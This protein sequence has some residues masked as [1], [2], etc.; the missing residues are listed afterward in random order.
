MVKGLPRALV[1]ATAGL[2]LAMLAGGGTVWAHYRS[3][4]TFR[5]WARAT[6]V[7]EDVWR[8]H[9]PAGVELGR[10]ESWRSDAGPPRERFGQWRSRST[11]EHGDEVLLDLEVEVRVECREVEDW[12]ERGVPSEAFEGL[13]VFL[14]ER[15]RDP[16]FHGVAVLTLHEFSAYADGAD[17]PALTQGPRMQL[18]VFALAGPGPVGVIVQQ[19]SRDGQDRNAPLLGDAEFARR[20]FWIAGS[21]MAQFLS[22]EDA[23][24]RGIAYQSRCTA[25]PSW[26]R[27]EGGASSGGMGNQHFAGTTRLYSARM[28]AIHAFRS[29]FDEPDRF[30]LSTTD[31]VSRNYQWNGEVW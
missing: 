18:D 31:E 17:L 9:V 10:G 28:Q 30:A 5:E 20:S 1:L 2:G 21:V 4:P 11:F 26:T 8:A 24:P 16:D 14:T 19:V 27:N 3:T 6:P 7:G 15:G 25:F 22:L 13:E 23:P 29:P 12:S